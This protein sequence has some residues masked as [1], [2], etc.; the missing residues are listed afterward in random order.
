MWHNLLVIKKIGNANREKCFEKSAKVLK[1]TIIR[2][3]NYK[4]LIKKVIKVTI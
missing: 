3:F 2:N 4:T 1:E